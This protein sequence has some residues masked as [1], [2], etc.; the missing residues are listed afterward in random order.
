ME[1]VQRIDDRT[2]RTSTVGDRSAQRSMS[3][4]T[5]AFGIETNAFTYEC[6]QTTLTA[7]H[8]LAIVG[9]FIV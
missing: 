5:E 4:P 8:G 6:E 9:E 7:A 1:W 2:D 3:T